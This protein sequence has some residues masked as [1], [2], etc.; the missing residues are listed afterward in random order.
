MNKL[1]LVFV[2]NFLLTQNALALRDPIVLLPGGGTVAPTATMSISLAGLV[3]TASYN[4][5]CYITTT[6]ALMVVR[7]GSNFTDTTSTIS[8][9][10]LN[11]TALTQGQ[12]NIG[13]NTAMIVGT[14]TNPS[15][16]NVTFTNLD[17]TNSFNVGGCF[18]TPTIG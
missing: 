9:Y 14:F 17:Q 13:Q 6:N 16:G 11:G 12:L 5:I 8:S 2:L 15:T 10:N 1:G 7:F 18:A 4:V 3:P